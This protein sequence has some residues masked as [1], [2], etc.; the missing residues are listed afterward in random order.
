MTSFVRSFVLAAS[1]VLGGCV[2]QAA[3]LQAATQRDVNAGHATD[4]GL[5]LE[6]RQIGADAEDAFSAQLYLLDG[7]K[8][9]PAVEARMRARGDLPEGY[10]S[11]E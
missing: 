8:L 9:A 2:P 4:E 6:A 11:S 10:P 7:T 3:L 5:P 1:F